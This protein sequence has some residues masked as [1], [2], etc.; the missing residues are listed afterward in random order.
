[1]ALTN[2]QYNEIMRG[3][4]SLRASNR[5]IE[6]ERKKALY[7]R[8]PE[9]K[10]ID[11]RI[12][13]LIF[14]YGKR[15]V[16]EEYDDTDLDSEL[17]LLKSKRLAILADLDISPAYLDPIYCCSICHDTGFVDNQKCSC[18]IK[19]E[20][21]LLY[22]HS[23]IKNLSRTETFDKFNFKL[24]STE[25]IDKATGLSAYDTAKKAYDK[26]RQ[27]VRN[28]AVADENLLL[29]GGTGVGKTFLTNCI[30][31][32]LINTSNSV[33]YLTAIELFDKLSKIAFNNESDDSIYDC[34]LLIIDDLGTEIKNS[35][36]DSYLFYLINYRI[37]KKKSTI[38]ST[39]FGPKELK[40]NYSER[41]FSRILRSY[42]T[43]KLYNNDI[44]L[45]EII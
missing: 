8:L 34:D 39:N 20:I 29:Y 5:H 33:V 3:Y 24:Y 38:I 1:M 6:A 44:R 19:A 40:Q 41:T 22:S 36:T 43:L 35:F 2:I 12:S 11:D 25:N 32:E 18:F 14:S 37:L 7:L 10:E 13:S 9:L 21:D 26:C 28:F 17:E 42:T 4:D 31:N 27:F 30:A 15:A 16:M 23:N 45:N